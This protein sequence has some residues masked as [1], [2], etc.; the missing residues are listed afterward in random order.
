MNYFCAIFYSFLI[1]YTDLCPINA[2]SK[3]HKK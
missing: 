1:D 2:T 3:W